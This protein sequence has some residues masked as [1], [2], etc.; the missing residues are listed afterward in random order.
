[1]ALTLNKLDASVNDPSVFQH[2]NGK[3]LLSKS[4]IYYTLVLAW[5]T[6]VNFYKGNYKLVSEM[7]TYFVNINILSIIVTSLFKRKK[8]MVIVGMFPTITYGICSYY[9]DKENTWKYC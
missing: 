1:M 9:I 7:P 2:S 6:T 8:C 3:N 4:N 5:Y